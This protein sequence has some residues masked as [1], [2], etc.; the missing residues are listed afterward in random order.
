MNNP[1]EVFSGLS[2][3]CIMEETFFLWSCW[4]C[5]IMKI[6]CVMVLLSMVLSACITSGCLCVLGIGCPVET[7]IIFVSKD[8]QACKS[9]KVD[10]S[11][12]GNKFGPFSDQN[13][14]GC[15]SNPV[16]L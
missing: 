11:G 10:C 1:D 7:K 3:G 2:D 6:I 14:C 16:Y 12:Y 9:I 13:N 8:P 5:I 4:E 15:V